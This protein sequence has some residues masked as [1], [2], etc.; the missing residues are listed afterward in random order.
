MSIATIQAEVSSDS[1]SFAPDKSRSRRS[2]LSRPF[3]AT[4]SLMEW[5]FGVLSLILGLSVLATIPILQ[6]ASLGYLLESAARV[7]QSGRIRDGVIGVRRAARLGGALLAIWLL[8]QPLRLLIDL[9]YSAQLL[10][11]GDDL[12][13]WNIGLIVVA[14]LTLTHIMWACVR[15]AQLR[16]FMWPAPLRFVRHCRSVG[17]RNTYRDCRDGWYEF[18][19]ALR[20]PFYWWKGARGFIVAFV[21]LFVPISFM[22]ISSRLPLGAGLILALVTSVPLSIV[23]LHL[24]FLQVNFAAANRFRAGFDWRRVR[25]QFR[26]APIAFWFALLWTLVLALPLYILKAE[27]IPRD[28]AWMPSIVFVVSIFPARVLTGWAVSRAERRTTPRHFVTRWLSRLAFVPIVLAYAWIAYLTQF[29]SW[30]GAWSL[31]EQHAFLL[32]VPF[33]GG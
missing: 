7:S 28:A 10:R 30:H 6:F 31:Y 12:R 26:R 20:L 23:L 18:V 22:V 5:L 2:V 9:R 24:P 17:L 3:I 27:L 8:L 21:W 19:C 16:H 32:P 33:L 15:G 25:D 29:V 11:P 13:A 14:G 4:K 1:V